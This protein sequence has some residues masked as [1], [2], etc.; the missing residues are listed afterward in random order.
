[1]RNL[2]MLMQSFQGVCIGFIEG[3]HRMDLCTK[4]IRG[5]NF[6]PNCRAA[7]LTCLPINNRVLPPTSTVYVLRPINIVVETEMSSGI[8][9]TL[10]KQYSQD[11][12]DRANRTIKTSPMTMLQTM[13]EECEQNIIAPKQNLASFVCGESMKK[14]DFMEVFSKLHEM[15]A[16]YAFEKSPFRDMIVPRRDETED[17]T[18]KAL[19]NCFTAYVDKGLQFT[20]NEHLRFV[21]KMDIVKE[22]SGRIQIDERKAIDMRGQLDMLSYDKQ[23]VGITDLRKKGCPQE[24]TI[25]VYELAN[26][27]TFFPVTRQKFLAFVSSI[28]DETREEMEDIFWFLLHVLVPCQT[29]SEIISNYGFKAVMAKN[30]EGKSTSPPFQDAVVEYFKKI[31]GRSLATRRQIKNIAFA[32]FFEHYLEFLTEFNKNPKTF[33]GHSNLSQLGRSIA[34]TLAKIENEYQKSHI[35][36]SKKRKGPRK[37]SNSDKKKTTKHSPKKEKETPK[38]GTDNSSDGEGKKA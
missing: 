17:D 10:L 13:C 6:G 37:K 36:S 29:L 4:L 15:V 14:A 32:L 3:G 1:M 11:L 2:A 33:N 7:P 19:R 26:L 38:K 21:L 20:T 34:V 28:T 27:F 25:L 30:N 5:F 8:N 12:Q 23:S 18:R 16:T 24:V 31:K 22:K 35:E 9:A